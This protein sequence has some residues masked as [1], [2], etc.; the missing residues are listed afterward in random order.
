M[1]NKLFSK[2]VTSSIWLEPTPTRM[3]WITFLALMDEDGF[4]PVASVANLAHTARIDLED[5][6]KAV[7]RRTQ[8]R[9]CSWRLDGVKRQEIQGHSNTHSS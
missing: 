3:I 9:A 6:T 7:Q 1:Y 8:N 5:A 2:I 4:A